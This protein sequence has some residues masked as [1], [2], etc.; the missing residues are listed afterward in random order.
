MEPGTDEIKR[1]TLTA[2]RLRIISLMLLVCVVNV[3][4]RQNVGFAAL[5]MNKDLHF[6]PEVFGFGVSMF[7]VSYS[8]L[9]IPNGLAFQYFGARRVLTVVLILWGVIG[10]AQALVNNAQSFF[11]LRFLM[12]AAEAG[13]PGG[14]IL[15]F[16]NWMPREARARAAAT[17]TFAI[18]LTIVLLSAGS[19]WLLDH[20]VGGLSG[21]R[22]MY[23]AEGAPAVLLGVIIFFYLPD[24][25]KEARWLSPVQ[26][27]W[28][29]G[30]LEREAASIRM[31]GSSTF[32]HVW[33]DARVWLLCIVW[34]SI[35]LG[36]YALQYW[37]PLAVQQ[38][39]GEHLTN[40]EVGLISALP[41]VGAVLGTWINSR[42]SDKTQERYWHLG[43]AMLLA[44][45][46]LMISLSLRNPWLALLGL[47]LSACGLG[48]AHGVFWTVPMSFLTGTA[49]ATGYSLLNLCG[50]LS[51]FFGSSV[52]GIVR[53]RTGSFSPA[54]YLIAAL[55]IV[56]ATLL[57][58]IRR[59][60]RSRAA[61]APPEAAIPSPTFGR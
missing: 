19:G 57:V 44:A 14:I 13:V 39:S 34:F 51:G 20:P 29:T 31:V 35:L 6:T 22:W 36:F 55:M 25:P 10:S 23:L 56:C 40:A 37:L 28:L 1:S 54:F 4:D 3:V 49:A 24:S 21:W 8:I 33:T 12:G 58:P 48:A 50:N 11:V 15:L 2:V 53:E 59:L 30:E 46:L 43:G 32:R 16:G 5:Q 61:K 41:W 7:F 60:T 17:N 52:V 42:H 26:R 27:A 9:Q 18:S 47:T 45:C 38:I